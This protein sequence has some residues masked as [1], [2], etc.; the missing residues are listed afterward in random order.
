MLTININESLIAFLE[1]QASLD[2]V[3]VE[4]WCER[5][6]NGVLRGLMREQG[7]LE[8]SRAKPENLQAFLDAVNVV[9]DEIKIAEQATKTNEELN[10]DNLDIWALQ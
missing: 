6:I 5:K 8:I 2:N 4:L 9:K 7:I 10:D 3:S 1:K